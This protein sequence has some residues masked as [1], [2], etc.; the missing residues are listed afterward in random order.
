MLQVL[1]MLLLSSGPVDER[2]ARARMSPEADAV[3]LLSAPE[4]QI[5]ATNPRLR[6]LIDRGV[7]RSYTFARLVQDLHDTDVIVYVEATR[8]LPR[9]VDGHLFLIPSGDAQRYLRVQ[10]RPDLHPDETI[11]LIAHELRHALEVGAATQVRTPDGFAALYKRIGHT[12]IGGHR[13]DT[14]AAQQTGRTVRRE[15]GG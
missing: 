2:A 4:R 14:A 11:A 8:N 5:R 1:V 10:V 3:R 13:Y 6:Q 12:V 15:L 7:R 9:L